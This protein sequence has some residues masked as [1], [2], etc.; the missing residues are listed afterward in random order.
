M[1]ISKIVD[2]RPKWFYKDGP[3]VLSAFLNLSALCHFVNL[4]FYE[5]AI[6]STCHFVSLSAFLKLS[7][8]IFCSALCHFV[9]L[10]FCQLVILII[11]STCHS[12]HFIHGCFRPRAEPGASAAIFSR[13]KLACSALANNLN[14]AFGCKEEPTHVCRLPA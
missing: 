12:Y 8:V 11:L 2:S 9:N 13:N 1:Y 6:L 4:S 10:P 3:E 14:L 7:A 5:L